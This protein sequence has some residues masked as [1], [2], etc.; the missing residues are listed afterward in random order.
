L[1]HLIVID[2][3]GLLHGHASIEE[4]NKVWNALHVVAAGDNPKVVSANLTPATNSS[5]L[6]IASVTL[7]LSA[8]V[9]FIAKDIESSPPSSMPVRW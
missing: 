9:I 6:S 3:A 5:S 2:P 8:F 1:F 7:Q 4:H